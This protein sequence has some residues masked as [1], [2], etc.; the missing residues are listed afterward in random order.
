MRAHMATSAQSDEI[1]RMIDQF[2]RTEF[3]ERNSMMDYQPFFFSTL[4]AYILI[5]IQNYFSPI[6][7]TQPRSP[8]AST[9]LPN[10]SNPCVTIQ[11]NLSHVFGLILGYWLAKTG[12]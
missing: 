4:R 6:F 11:T 8:V 2:P 12:L 3:R 7:I 10:L 9:S 1:I 5:P